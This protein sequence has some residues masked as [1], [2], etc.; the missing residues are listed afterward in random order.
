MTP[1]LIAAAVAYQCAVT[2]FSVDG[3]KY[4]CK[5]CTRNDVIS[6]VICVQIKEKSDEKTSNRTIDSIVRSSSMGWMLNAN[7]H[8]AQRESGG[9]HN[10]LRF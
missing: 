10:L 8:Y 3:V 6:S 2:P 9:V 4:L 1:Y 5:T 7:H